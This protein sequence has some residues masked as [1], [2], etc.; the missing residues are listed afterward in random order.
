MNTL[1]T[2]IGS[3]YETSF[4]TYGRQYKVMVQALP[5]YR[6][7]PEDIMK[8]YVKNDHDE[9]VP[10]SAFMK[11][12]KVYGLSEITRHNMYNAAEISG[13]S[14]PG[15]S[16][17]A[18]IKAVQEVA[19]KTL[20]RGFGIDWAGISADEVARGNE[21]IFIFLICLGF[22]YLILAGQYESFILPLA[23]IL[24]LPAGIFGTFV[25]LKVVGL[26]NNIYAQVAMVMLIGLLGKNA[27]LI[28]EF[29]VQRHRAGETVLKAALQGAA[30]R[31]R[32]IL[33]TS[34]AFIAG[35]IPLVFAH[36]PGALGN[37]TIGTAALGGMLFGTVFGVL[38][39]PPL[40]YV[41]GKIAER[42]QLVKYEDEN[43]LTEEIDHHIEKEEID[44]Y[45]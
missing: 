38:I 35:L 42:V 7:L 26:E 44:H 32:P 6:A 20:P 41:F 19:Q 5:Q 11:M 28:V 2:L 23:V 37:R 21:A 40:Y 9:M 14:A 33:M 18:A 39:I 1:S 27:V 22:V 16:S 36:G 13:T 15:F 25:L 4:I 10:F 45:V 8:L 24:S 34:F 3:N 43:P 17:G 30:I 29:A 31:F 12:E